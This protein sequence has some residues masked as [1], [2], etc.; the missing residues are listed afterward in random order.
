[1]S[2]LTRDDRSEL[3]LWWWSVDRWSLAAL[4][5]LIG[6]G[7][8]LV[9]AAAPAAGARIGLEGF[10]LAQRQLLLLP[11]ALLVMALAS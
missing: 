4:V 7:V 8:V 6:F 1:M 3:A 11:L 2:S 9:M 10:Y 5:L